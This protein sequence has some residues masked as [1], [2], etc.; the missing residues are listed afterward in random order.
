LVDE[1]SANRRRDKEGRSGSPIAF[2]V[3]TAEG[4]IMSTIELL[5]GMMLAS[6]S[7]SWWYSIAKVIET[8]SA[9][10]KSRGFVLLICLGYLLG[11]TSKLIGWHQTGEVSPIL[12]VYVCNLLVIVCDTLLIIRYSRPRRSDE[13]ATP[14]AS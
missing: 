1:I 8:K 6:F 11:I 4:G 5:E 7:V 3:A 13:A 14:A 10:G 2:A 9:C 12:W